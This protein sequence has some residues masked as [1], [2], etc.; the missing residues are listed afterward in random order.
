[1]P[2]TLNSLSNNINNFDNS[3]LKI[4]NIINYDYIIK[5]KKNK[6]IIRRKNDLE[7]RL[8]LIREE[9]EKSKCL[10]STKSS[11][12]LEDEINPIK[13]NTKN[14]RLSK[15]LK[16]Y[17]IKLAKIV[18]LLEKVL[19]S[20]YIYDKN[21]FLLNLKII[22]LVTHIKK[23]INNKY[24]DINIIKYITK[25]NKDKMIY[26]PKIKNQKRKK[27]ISNIYIK[28]KIFFNN[29]IMNENIISSHS[30]DCNKKGQNAVSYAFCP[31]PFSHVF[32][33]AI[34]RRIVLHFCDDLQNLQEHLQQFHN[35]VVYVLDIVQTEEFL[36]E[37]DFLFGRHVLLSENFARAR[38]RFL[39]GL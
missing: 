20:F 38:L 26:Y 6:K 13:K 21:K 19:S 33:I 2:Y 17:N 5:N 18:Y 32:L 36:H 35:D 8:T 25:I 10:N 24:R 28:D 37:A 30:F 34:G 3:I 11:K 31:S 27:N 22:C 9:D 39:F 23:I 7:D 1:M 16:K 12:L 14:L 4:E 29:I 15:D